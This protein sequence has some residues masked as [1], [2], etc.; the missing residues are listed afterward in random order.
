MTDLPEISFDGDVFT[1]IGIPPDVRYEVSLTAQKVMVTMYQIQRDLQDP[2]V[3]TNYEP[4]EPKVL[5]RQDVISDQDLKNL[6]NCLIMMGISAITTVVAFCFL[7]SCLISRNLRGGLLSAGAVV[8]LGAFTRYCI[9]QDDRAKL[10]FA[11]QAISLSQ[12]TNVVYD[13][14]HY[15]L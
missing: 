11:S 8:G 9:K 12:G 7:G 2:E 5:N 6:D 3:V 14:S 4:K 13:P 10:T 15:G 1:P